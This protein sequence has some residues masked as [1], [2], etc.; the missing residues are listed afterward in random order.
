MP[1]AATLNPFHQANRAVVVADLA[2]HL[3]VEHRTADAA[4]AEACG[5]S[6]EQWLTLAR[7]LGHYAG[8]DEAPADDTISAVLAS[9]ERMQPSAK[10]IADPFAGLPL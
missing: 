1:S 10:V 4:L 9:L 3:L 7:D 2:R 8:P 5:L 6:D